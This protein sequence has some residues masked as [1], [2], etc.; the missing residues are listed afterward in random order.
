MEV[1]IEHI[2]AVQFEIKAQS[3]PIQDEP[4]GGGSFQYKTSLEQMAC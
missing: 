4:E 1:L 2:G 3:F